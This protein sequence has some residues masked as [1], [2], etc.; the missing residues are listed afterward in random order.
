M[1]S[2]AFGDARPFLDEVRNGFFITSAVKTA[3]HAEMDILK[4]VDR[5]CR[6]YNIQYFADWGS[7]LAA[8]RHGGYIPWDDDLDICMKRRDYELFIRH[9]DELPEEYF[10]STYKNSPDHWFYITRVQNEKNVSFDSE[11][12]KKIII[13]PTSP[14]WIYSFLIISIEMMRRK[15]RVIK[16]LCISLLLLTV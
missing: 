15:R 1:I 9:S 11:Y 12:L 3:W 14:A 8:V 2:D 10:L 6:K 7:L 5:V 4:E 13:S 16:R